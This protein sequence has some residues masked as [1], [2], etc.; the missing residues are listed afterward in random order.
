MV[1]SSKIIFFEKGREKSSL[2]KGAIKANLKDDFYQNEKIKIVSAFDISE[3]KPHLS[4]VEKRRKI[5]FINLESYKLSQIK[6]NLKMLKELTSDVEIILLRDNKNE[7]SK[8]LDGLIFEFPKDLGKAQ[9][10]IKKVIIQDYKSISKERISSLFAKKKNRPNVFESLP[11]FIKK[12]LKASSIGFFEHINL[13]NDLELKPLYILGRKIVA[14]KRYVSDISKK[15]FSLFDVFRYGNVISLPIPQNISFLLSR[16]EGLNSFERVFLSLLLRKLCK[17]CNLKK[18]LQA[19]KVKKNHEEKPFESVLYD[20]RDTINT[21]KSVGYLFNGNSEDLNTF[22]NLKSIIYNSCDDFLFLITDI[23][24]DKNNVELKYRTS[25]VS[26]IF[27]YIKDKFDGL[28]EFYNITFEL[29]F[30]N[31]EKEIDCDGMKLKRAI[32]YLINSSRKIL[33]YEGIENPK[34]TVNFVEKNKTYLFKVYNNGPKFSKNESHEFFESMS[35]DED[36]E[37]VGLGYILAKKIV[38]NHGGTLEIKAEEEG[39]EGTQFN[40]EIPKDLLAA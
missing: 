2:L 14:P 7:K 8:K 26:S 34:I 1:S 16:K 17:Y 3:V 11:A 18:T 32:G 19:E 23:I 12:E 37:H 33:L 28:L 13:D 22:S 10:Y 5:V 9:T 4:R 30:N 27:T 38:E 40:L 6:K 29:S 39:E 36:Q 25:N 21:I 24:H 35:F 20:L 31:G 15:S